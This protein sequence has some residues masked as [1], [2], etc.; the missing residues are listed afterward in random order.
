MPS[1]KARAIA[2]RI[3][4][5]IETPFMV[6]G[7][8][9]RLGASIGMAVVPDDALEAHAALEVA[10]EAMYREKRARSASR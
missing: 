2:A 6:G 5:E 3:M 4:S 8:P 10:D 1:S 9:V 7:S